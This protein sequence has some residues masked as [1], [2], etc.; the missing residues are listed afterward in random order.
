MSI[1]ISRLRRVTST[2]PPR[3]L[4]YGPPGMGKTTLA[5]EW[6]SPIFLQAEDGTPA[7][8]EL[9]SFGR[10]ESYDDI[11]AAIG[12]LYESA[13]DG[14]T[15]VLDSLDRVEPLVWQKACDTR[16][17][18]T[19]EAPGYGK[20]Y[21]ECD[22]LWRELIAGMNAL[23]Y[24]RDM[25]V[26][27]VAHS[28]IVT[29]DDPMTQSYSRFDIK[30]HKR[31][32]GIFQDEVDAILF[33]NQDIVIKT[34]SKSKTQRTRADG[35]GHRWIYTAPRPAFVAKN[36]YGIPDRLEFKKGTGYL[37]LSPHF[38]GGKQNG[39]NSQSG[40]QNGKPSKTGA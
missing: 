5:A 24:E 13:H 22:T 9:T 7:G 36:R 12:A 21:V 15:V 10:L 23:R 28:A 34:D 11:I 32:M 37:S 20:G 14:K 1:D 3:T 40:K 6:P 25:A 18:E 31:A 17:W 4:I 8:L 27:Y 2:D 38:P 29:V 19:I 33:L 26:V 35:G 30:L 16:G 39:Q